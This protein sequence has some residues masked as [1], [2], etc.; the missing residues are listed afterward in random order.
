MSQLPHISP[1]HSLAHSVNGKYNNTSQT[2]PERGEEGVV[3]T[4]VTSKRQAGLPG[5]WKL[6]GIGPRP[7]T[8]TGW[9]SG[10]SCP[11]S[12]WALAG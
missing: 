2:S 9:G 4:S 7:P 3:E 10:V 8:Q 6:R 5:L 11:R 12:A 1:P